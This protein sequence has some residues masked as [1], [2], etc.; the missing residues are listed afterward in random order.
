MTIKELNEYSELEK[1]VGKQIRYNLLSSIDFT[2]KD[3]IALF[4][5]TKLKK[6]F[7][8]HRKGVG[9]AE[10]IFMYEQVLVYVPPITSEK[11]PEYFGVSF[12]DF[13]EFSDPA[14]E[15]QYIFP[16]LNHPIRY[17]NKDLRS[18]LAPLL[19]RYPPTWERWHEVLRFTGGDKWFD[20]ADVSYNY[21]DAYM[22]IDY[23]NSRKELLHTES[24]SFISKDIKQQIRNNFTNLCLIGATE[25]AV[26]LGKESYSNP[27]GA[28]NELLLM[29]E[30]YSYPRVLG[31]GI[32]NIHLKT[33]PTKPGNLEINKS[34]LTNDLRHY[35]YKVL[36]TLFNGLQFNSIPKFFRKTFIKNWHKS[37]QAKI[38]RK[39][40]GQLILNAKN[41]KKNDQEIHE[42][43]DIILRELNDFCS[44][45]EP[46]EEIINIE[47]EEKNKRINKVAMITSLVTGILGLLFKPLEMWLASSASSFIGYNSTT[48][49]EK[50]IIKTL[51]KQYPDIDKGLFQTYSQLKNI[52]FKLED[53]NA[54]QD[55]LIKFPPNPESILWRGA[56]TER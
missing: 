35:D 37:N 30:Y 18:D 50:F 2:I 20:I 38:V 22:I 23:R 47:V 55:T 21:K 25:Y 40:Y 31:G 14:S 12:E 46:S 11:F 4:P 19:K 9:I 52:S 16:F 51:K 49:R 54:S 39:A 10:M 43:I 24:K 3:P 34:L 44:N 8:L 13:L 27:I 28:L 5:D 42:V 56:D 32:A 26:D 17:K 1:I 53:I 6:G 7:G 29:S 48:E 41:R 45:A 15:D 33:R 36:L